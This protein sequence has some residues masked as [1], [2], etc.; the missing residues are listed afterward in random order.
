MAII[1][2][3]RTPEF[4][5]VREKNQRFVSPRLAKS[6]RTLTNFSANYIVS[7]T[8]SLKPD[9]AIKDKNGWKEVEKTDRF[10]ADSADRE[11]RG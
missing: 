1:Q 7:W 10:K 3:K 11:G 5:K 9:T 2:T 4:Q 6:R 8:T